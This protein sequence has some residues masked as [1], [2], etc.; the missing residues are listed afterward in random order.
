MSTVLHQNILR[1]MRPE[2]RARLGTAGLTA[3]E[4]E[5][6]C[7]ARNE[8]D[9]Q[10]LIKTMLNRYGIYVVRS[11]MDKRTTTAKGT[12]DLLFN[13]PGVG[14][15]AWE[16]KMPGKHPTPEQYEAM[17]QMRANG[18]QVAVIRSYDEA[19]K[20][21]KELTTPRGTADKL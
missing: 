16:V 11:R 15:I 13:L 21:Y 2:D 10:V 18:W 3:E 12:P 6:A 8:S 17:E 7:V 4:A 1:L 14:A 5:A 20:L 9:L 19:L